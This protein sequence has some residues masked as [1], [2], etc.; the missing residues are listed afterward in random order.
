MS[1]TSAWPLTKTKKMSQTEKFFA[2]RTF[3]DT[4][5]SFQIEENGEYYYIG[6]EVI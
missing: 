6:S 4:P 5:K 3:G 1:T 2:G